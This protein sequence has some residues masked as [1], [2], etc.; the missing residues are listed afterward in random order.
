MQPVML[1]IVND[2]LVQVSPNQTDIISG[3]GK[4]LGKPTA[5]NACP[6]YKDIGH[7]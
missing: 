5:H 7:N 6:E 4:E 3:I 1:Y 2:I